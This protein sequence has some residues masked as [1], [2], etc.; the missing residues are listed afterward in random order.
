[1]KSQCLILKK[2]TKIIENTKIQSRAL[3]KFKH[4]TT[5]RSALFIHILR[6]TKATTKYCCHY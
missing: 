3:A 1:M 6:V 4:Y 2:Q 5:S